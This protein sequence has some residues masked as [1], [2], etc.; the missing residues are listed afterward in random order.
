[1]TGNNKIKKGIENSVWSFLARQFG[2][3]PQSV[4]ATVSKSFLVIHLQGFLLPSEKTLLKRHEEQK[5]AST[6][7]LVL[8]EGKKYFLQELSEI[9][10][11]KVVEMYAA[12]NFN[13][14]SG[15]LIG[16]L[17]KTKD[18][19]LLEDSLD[20]NTLALRQKIIEMTEK[21]EKKPDSTEVYSLNKNTVLVER[22]GITTELEKEMI[23][24]GVVE[25]LKLAKR[26]LE[27]QYLETAGFEI[28]FKHKISELFVTWDFKQD[29]SYLVFFV[30]S[31]AE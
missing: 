20:L 5:I 19:G 15:V 11:E 26:T 23:K 1:M 13:N 27:H 7:E 2:Q 18:Q 24:N 21:T 3:E 17:E 8:N 4:Q 30:K 28:L 9:I 14:E 22:T 6:R 29:K 12:W 25:E 10:G 31:E 16:I